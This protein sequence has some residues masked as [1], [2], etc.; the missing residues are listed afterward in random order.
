MVNL[1]RAVNVA[2]SIQIWRQRL[3]HSVRRCLLGFQAVSQCGICQ[4]PG[5]EP[6]KHVSLS[7]D[8]T[9]PPKCK[10]PF[11]RKRSVM[12][13]THLC[14]KVEFVLQYIKGLYICES[15]YRC[16]SG[17]FFEIIKTT[18]Y[19]HIMHWRFVFIFL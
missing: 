5:F 15:W 12:S 10:R 16:T 19:K 8:K 1:Y 6:K 18:S 4:T 17:Q 3:E 11:C 2:F 13:R 14:D 7:F 9:P